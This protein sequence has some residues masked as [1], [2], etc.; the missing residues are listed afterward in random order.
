MDQLDKSIYKHILRS[1]AKGE[2]LFALLIDPDKHSA[3]SIEKLMISIKES[4]VD[5][6]L[7]GGSLLKSDLDKTL[8]FLKDNCEIPVV[9]FPGSVLQLSS[10][11]DGL[12]LLSLISGRNPEL[13][14]GNHVLAA[15]KIKNSGLEV[16]STGYILVDG[17]RVTSVEYMSNTKPIPADKIDI[18]CATALASEMLGHKMIYLE[19]GSGAKQTVMPEMV[20]AVRKL[21][22]IPIIVGGG[23]R[24]KL[25]AKE[26]YEAGADIIVTGTVIEENPFILKEISQ[27]SFE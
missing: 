14:I 8:E 23:I 3:Q 18:A 24:T 27:E 1:K 7:V 6:I 16:I 19:A 2:K 21:V 11:A 4:K 15:H 9:L 20:S 26:L 13:L 5:L 12:L 25:Q 17:K 10:K 22:D